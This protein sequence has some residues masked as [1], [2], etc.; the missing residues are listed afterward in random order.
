MTSLIWPPGPPTRRL[1]TNPA[2]SMT[3]EQVALMIQEDVRKQLR[4]ATLATL[5]RGGYDIPAPGATTK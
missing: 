3:S 4:A 2:D 5:R 1:F